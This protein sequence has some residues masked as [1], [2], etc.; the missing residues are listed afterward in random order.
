MKP[1]LSKIETSYNLLNKNNKILVLSAIL[2]FL[3]FVWYPA[4]S[5][6]LA[7]MNKN[8][9]DVVQVKTEIAVLKKQVLV[10]K[11]SKIDNKNDVYQKEEEKLKKSLA[12]IIKK[13]ESFRYHLVSSKEVFFNLKNMLVTDKGPRL[14][15]IKYLPEELVKDTNSQ[16]VFRSPIELTVQGTFPEILAY[17]KKAEKTNSFIFW[18]EMDYKVTQYPVAILKLKIYVVTSE[19]GK[20]NAMVL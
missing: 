2:L 1:W 16:P 15:S 20:E 10:L 3:F 8:K 19:E 13:I 4:T 14:V 7:R 18:D 5:N 6:L 17:L 12:A 11:S 9:K